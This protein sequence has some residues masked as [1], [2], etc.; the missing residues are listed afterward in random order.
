MIKLVVSD[1]DGT[2]LNSGEVSVSGEVLESIKKLKQSGK[3]VA[4][5][6]G[7][8]YAALEK[9]FYDVKDGLYFICCDGAVT[10]KDS[11]ALYTKQ[12]GSQD[13][14]DVIK[15]DE[16]S[17]CGIVL[18]TPTMSYVLRGGE[19]ICAVAYLESGEKPALLP[20]LY[21]LKE[22][23]CKIAVYSPKGNIKPL[24]FMPKSLRVSYCQGNWCEYTSAI[25]DKGAALSDLQM[26]L[27]LS[28]FDTAALGDGIND[29]CMM[30]KAKIAVSV[31]D[32]HVSLKEVCG[33]HTNNAA[34]FLT[35]LCKE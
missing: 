24:N 9:L 17:D 4:I 1:V 2:L 20:R 21:D 16:Y 13:L 15:R 27:Y 30:K 33:Q 29:V 11:K 19:E 34:L 10:V 35:D 6:S 18:C 14:F 32:A 28:K 3:T 5:A 25:A 23:V 26:R 31:N 8:T 7:R 22:P 12:I